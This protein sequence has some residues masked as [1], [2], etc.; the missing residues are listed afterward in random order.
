VGNFWKTDIFQN[1]T[2]V[3]FVHVNGRSLYID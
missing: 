1:V 3:I 2:A